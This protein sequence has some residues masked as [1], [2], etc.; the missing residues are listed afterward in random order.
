M[1]I[2]LNR[3]TKIDSIKHFPTI[4]NEWWKIHE[5]IF[6][7]YNILSYVK[8]MLQ[9]WDSKETILEIIEELEN[10]CKN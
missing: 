9:R 5:S 2:E 3:R 10:S 6:R 1:E 8:E 7:S 4:W